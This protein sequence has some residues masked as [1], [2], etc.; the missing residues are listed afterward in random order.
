MLRTHQVVKNTLI[1]PPLHLPALPQLVV[2]VV[3]TLPMLSEFVQATL[4]DICQHTR[5]T[6]GHLS[7]L[8]QALSL[9]LA[10]GLGLADHEVIVEGFAARTDEEAGG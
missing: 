8:L 10:I 4:V 6:T 3:Q 2:V 7:T 5:G 9:A 1:Q